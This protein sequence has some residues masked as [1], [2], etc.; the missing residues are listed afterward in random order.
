MQSETKRLSILVV[1]NNNFERDSIC[2]FLI[3][4]S[5]VKLVDSSSN[6]YEAIWKLKTKKYDLVILNFEVGI[7][8]GIEIIRFL[9]S[10]LNDIKIIGISYISDSQILQEAFDLGL[11]YFFKKPFNLN[12]INKII[13]NLTTENNKYKISNKMLKINSIVSKIGIST[14]L[15]GF[16]Y[17][18][19]I[20]KI[21]YI[22]NVSV[23]QAYEKIAK[24]NNTSSDCIEVNIRNA[25]KSAH[26][27]HNECYSKIFKYDLD[28]KPKNSVFL[29]TILNFIQC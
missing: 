13:N 26:L 4:L 3:S 27:K 29:H 21:I 14:N 17:I 9:K 2:Y 6:G 23:N 1:E 25:I 24:I 11:N 10:N 8:D 20:L 28:K 12:S 5:N 15:L 22:E 18:C 19:D 7:T 16:K